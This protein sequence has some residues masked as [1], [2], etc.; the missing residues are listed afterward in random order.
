MVNKS[1]NDNL[2]AIVVPSWFVW[3]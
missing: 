3:F 1:M 2:G